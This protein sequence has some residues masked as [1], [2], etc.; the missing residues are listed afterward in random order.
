MVWELKLDFEVLTPLFLG[1]ADQSAELRAPSIKGLLRFWY[2]A[3]DPGFMDEEQRIFGGTTGGAGQSP[4]L[5]RI[6]SGPPKLARWQDFGVAKFSQ[7]TGRDTRNGLIYL[8]FP[9][10][11]RGNEE[12]T[13]I[14]PGHGFSVRCLLPR[15]GADNTDSPLQLRRRLA[16]AWWLLGHLGGAGSRSRRGFGS[17]ALRDWRAA[18]GEW[19]E[20]GELPLLS[21]A[22]SPQEGRAGLDKGLNTLRTWFGAWPED[23]HTTRHPHLGGA[24]RFRLLDTA[25]PQAQWNKALADMGA[26]MQDFRLCRA[27]DYQMVKDHLLAVAREGGRPLQTAPPRASFGLPLAFRYSSVRGQAMFVPY[28]EAGHSTFERH[29]SLLLLRLAAIGDNLHPLYVRMDGAAPGQDPPAALRKA[30]RPL[31]PARENAM[32]AFFDTLGIGKR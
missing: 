24:F 3:V 32:D 4:F 9:F 2:R 10:Q 21:H 29:G 26:A 7:G 5:M 1:G 20:L 13:A 15:T 23:K 27:P 31:L 28:D 12:R 16:A 17:L 25:Y 6:E 22:K 30:S 14:A 18:K 8:G 11:M 19:P